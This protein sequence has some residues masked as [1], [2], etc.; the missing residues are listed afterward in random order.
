MSESSHTPPLEGQLYAKVENFGSHYGNGG[1]IVTDI[2]QANTITSL[3]ANKVT[4]HK[5]VV[6]IDFPAKLIPSST[7]GH[8]HLYIDHEIPADVYWELLEAMAKAGLVEEKYVEASKAQGRTTLRLPWV[9]KDDVAAEPAVLPESGPGS[10][11][12]HR[13]YKIQRA[14]TN[15]ENAKAENNLNLRRLQE[16]K[17]RYPQVSSEYHDSMLQVRVAREALAKEE[18]RLALGNRLDAGKR[19]EID[20]MAL[21][22]MLHVWRWSRPGTFKVDDPWSAYF[23]KVLH[24]KREANPALWTAA[25][26]ASFRNPE[27]K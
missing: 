9:R 2:E 24:D 19:K 20:D 1:N 7:E 23:E 18:Q 8:F 16:V 25:S 4:H 6:D 21:A 14:R 11:F 5:L 26:K 10:Q 12:F 3:I 15:L 22:E 27:E 13:H 17:T